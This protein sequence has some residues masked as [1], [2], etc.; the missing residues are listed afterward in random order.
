MQALTGGLGRGVIEEV[1]ARP[2]QWRVWFRLNP[3]VAAAVGVIRLFTVGGSIAHLPFNKID[4]NPSHSNSQYPSKQYLVHRNTPP[5]KA[6]ELVL[7]TAGA[8][9]HLTPLALLSI[10][11][12]AEALRSLRA[13]EMQLPS[14]TGTPR[15]RVEVAALTLCYDT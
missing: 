13:L 7:I 3:L 8:A 15:A 10:L 4:I 2:K 9:N 11:L 1:A 12:A 6:L 14:Y 5:S